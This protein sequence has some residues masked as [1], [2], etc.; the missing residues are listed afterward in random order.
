MKHTIIHGDCL[1]KTEL[2][3]NNSI[4]L[5]ITSPPYFNAKEYNNE[6]NNIGN[7]K[8]YMDYLVKI[9]KLIKTLFLKLKP[10]SI[11]CWNTSPVIMNKKRYGIP[12]DTHKIFLDNGFDFE[13]DIV[14]A[15]PDGAGGL[16]CGG[17]VQNGQKPMTWHP[18]IIT[19][20]IM[21]Y[22]KPGER[23]IK[24]YTKTNTRTKDLLTNVWKINPE[25]SVHWHDAP[26][27]QELAKR[28][29]EL[30]SFEGDI[31]LDPFGGSLTTMCV[32]RNLNRNSISIELNK[33][34]INK[35]K[36]LRGFGQQGLFSKIEYEEI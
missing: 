27:P 30:Y 24:P 9:D 7:N 8:D 11:I 10:G 13:E 29:I 18:N 25:T 5:V 20:Y 36:E 16:R 21:V 31:V 35:A 2:L 1:L 23:E 6:E 22:S 4:D 12:F 33:E 32:S 28:L 17:W 34:Y 15:K 3:L 19:E 14:W 26:Y